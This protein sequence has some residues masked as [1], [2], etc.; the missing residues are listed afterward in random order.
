MMK[1][2]SNN[3]AI[4]RVTSYRKIDNEPHGFLTLCP[5]LRE[6]Q[7]YWKN[8]ETE[9]AEIKVKAKKYL[10]NIDRA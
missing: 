10:K 9:Q 8:R 6:Q 3:S 2:L 4:A 5:Y 1:R 7:C